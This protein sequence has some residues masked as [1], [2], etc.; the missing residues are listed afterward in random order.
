MIS[1][2]KCTICNKRMKFSKYDTFKTETAE[3][4]AFFYV[5]NPP[6][7]DMDVPEDPFEAIEPD[8]SYID[9]D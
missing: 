9:Q 4:I 5:H 1:F 2:K 7:W 3:G 8:G 6:C